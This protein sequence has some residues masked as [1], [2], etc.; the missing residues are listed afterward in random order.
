MGRATFLVVVKDVRAQVRNRTI[1]VIGLVA[2]L[3]LAFVLN[4]VF[5]AAAGPTSVTF[6]VGLVS[7][8]GG[9][10]AERFTAVIDKASEAGFLEVERF[11][12]E[13]AARA[14]VDDGEVGAAWVLTEGT[15]DS[16]GEAARPEIVVLGNVDSPNT[17][18]LARSMAAFQ[19]RAGHGGP[20]YP[21]G[22]RDRRRA[23]NSGAVRGH[24]PGRRAP[25]GRTRAH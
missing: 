18:A 14:A 12:D 25:A 10:L 15:T 21:G 2:P 3:S 7:A 23:C 24:G 1:L 6:E 5:G 8:D 22:D 17:V 20:R 4:M 16:S 11:A 13:P 19:H 9:Q